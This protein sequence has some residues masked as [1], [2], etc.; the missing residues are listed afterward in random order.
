MS[1]ISTNDIKQ[2]MKLEIENQPY[3]VIS[4][5]FVK[6]GKGQ[7]FNR[8]R[9]KHLQS[10]RSIEKT[11]KSGEKLSLADVQEMRMRL[12]YLDQN[13]AVFMS[14]ETFEQMHI[15]FTAIKETKKWLKDDIIYDIIFYKGEAIEILPPTFMD[16]K[17]VETNPGVR[18]DTAS[19]RVLKPAILE[20]GANISIPIFIE[21]GEIIKVDTRT[22]EYVSRSQS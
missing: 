22:A 15:P 18:G 3:L 16:L 4:N 19:G 13:E 7:A 17:I 20:T 14:D 9:V 1:D 21:Q 6:P 5:E 2:G 10:G 11:Y 12:L 8:I